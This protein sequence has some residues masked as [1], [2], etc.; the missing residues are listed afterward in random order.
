MDDVLLDLLVRDEGWKGES[1]PVPGYHGVNDAVVRMHEDFW[2][3]GLAVVC[4]DII[5]NL[6]EPG[7]VLWQANASLSS[8]AFGVAALLLGRKWFGIF[9]P[10]KEREMLLVETMM[11][12]VEFLREEDEAGR[13]HGYSDE[14]KLFTMLQL[15]LADRGEGILQGAKHMQ[16][17]PLDKP[18]DFTVEGNELEVRESTVPGAGQG[19]FAKNKIKADN[20]VCVVAGRWMAA[21]FVKPD[22]HCFLVP[23]P[24]LPRA[25]NNYHLLYEVLD[26]PANKINDIPVCKT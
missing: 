15:V 21:A 1:L 11:Q 6:S 4:V 20:R 13:F 3:S 7:D 24:P 8:A 22:K 19:L 25:K 17:S 10:T 12:C 5:R 23:P 14:E 18:E 16:C 2:V 26:C 9:N